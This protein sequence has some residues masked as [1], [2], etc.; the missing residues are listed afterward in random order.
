MM[1]QQQLANQAQYGQA[2]YPQGQQAANF[3]YSPGYGY[4]QQQAY[5]FA[6]QGAYSQQG[7]YPQ[8]GYQAQPTATYQGQQGYPQPNPQAHGQQQHGTH[9]KYKEVKSDEPKLNRV[10]S[11][12]PQVEHRAKTDAKPADKTQ[13]ELKKPEQSK[14]QEPNVK[15]APKQKV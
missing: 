10:M 9:Q 13:H 14:V 11:T 12:P 5:G 2:Q 15:T 3:N 7:G 6:Q 8:G 4:Q 1:Y